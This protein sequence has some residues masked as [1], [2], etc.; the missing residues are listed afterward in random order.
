MSPQ[1]D[2]IL[3]AALALSRDERAALAARLIDSLH[4]GEVLDPGEAERLALEQ[5]ERRRQRNLR[6]ETKLVPAEEALARVR[7][8][9]RRAV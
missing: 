8:R 7:E 5:V 6:G 4:G 1:Y 3:T 9:V 2:Q